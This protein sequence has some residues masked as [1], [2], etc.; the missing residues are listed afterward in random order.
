MRAV[1]AYLGSWRLS[2]NGECC[3]WHVMN[4]E[5]MFRNRRLTRALL[6]AFA[7]Y[8]YC[9][10][11][12]SQDP[13]R[14]ITFKAPARKST[15]TTNKVDYANLNDGIAG[16]PRR[17]FRHLNQKPMKKNS[18]KHMQGSEVSLEWL[19]ED[20]SAMTEPV[21]IDNP[22]GLG[23]KMPP[24]TFTVA[25]V[26]KLVGPR[27]KVEVLGESVCVRPHVPI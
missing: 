15:R 22:E 1:L 18:F 13:S 14:V 4:R 7:S 21:I 8:R 10:G 17:W 6:S 11:C 20:D 5:L 19:R 23:M 26:A 16:D 25:D 24:S 27:E 9:E 12:I 3:D 2:I